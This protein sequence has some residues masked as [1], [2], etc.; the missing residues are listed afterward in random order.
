MNQSLLGSG[1]ARCHSPT[2]EPRH[3]DKPHRYNEIE[4]DRRGR[5]G[6]FRHFG[7][8]C[9]GRHR[10]RHL[11]RVLRRCPAMSC[12]STMPCGLSERRLNS[13]ARPSP[14][15]LCRQP[16]NAG[17]RCGETP[18]PSPGSSGHPSGAMQVAGGRGFMREKRI[19]EKAQRAKV[20]VKAPTTQ[21]GEFVREDPQG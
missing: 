19:V 15:P 1:R 20:A 17:R 12:S 16:Q 5:I 18:Q 6:H 21:A 11:Y 8:A 13:Q 14:S 2:T 3:G 9:P 4:Q 10:Q 7:S